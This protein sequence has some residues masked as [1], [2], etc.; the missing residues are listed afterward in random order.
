MRMVVHGI[1]THIPLSIIEFIWQYRNGL[2]PM[3]VHGMKIYGNM[4]P[5]IAI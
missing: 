4:Q 2:K 3:V 5:E 1:V